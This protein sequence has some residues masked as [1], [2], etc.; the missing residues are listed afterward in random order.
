MM[1]KFVFNRSYSIVFIGLIVGLACSWMAYSRNDTA[2][3]GRILMGSGGVVLILVSCALLPVLIYRTSI[4]IKEHGILAPGFDPEPLPWNLISDV[5]PLRSVN[6]SDLRI[7]LKA[8][9]CPIADRNRLFLK[10]ERLQPRD[11]TSTVVVDCK[12]FSTKAKDIAAL[13]NKVRDLP[14]IQRSAV[15]LRKTT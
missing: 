2:L 6:D 11:S 3:M 15:I 8:G 10:N 4:R 7:E 13:I 9:Y 12:P 14:P 5:S 1:D